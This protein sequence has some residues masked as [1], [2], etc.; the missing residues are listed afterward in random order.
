LRQCFLLVFL[1]KGE[2]HCACDNAF[3]DTL[4]KKGN[5]LKNVSGSAFSGLKQQQ[6][7]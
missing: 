6:Q 7:K 2:K 3:L 5:T 4:A 1:Q